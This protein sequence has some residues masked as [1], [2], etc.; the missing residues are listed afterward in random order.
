MEKDLEFAGQVS[1]LQSAVFNAWLG[2]RL[3]FEGLETALVGDILRKRDTGGLFLCEDVQ[4]DSRRLASGELDLCGPLF[5]PKMKQASAEAAARENTF[6]DRLAL[7][8]SAKRNVGRFGAGGR[9]PSRVLAD[10]VT[11][12]VEGGDL[13]IAFTLPS[14]A[15]ATVFLAELMQPNAGWVERGAV[16]A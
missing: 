11:H 5:G 1:A 10:N 14:G 8:E 9:R 7:D 6:V 2:Q 13:N 15:Y 16:K 3:R 4:T 12:T